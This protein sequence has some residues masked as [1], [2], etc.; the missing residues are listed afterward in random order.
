[1]QEAEAFL[2]AHPE[3]HF[4]DLLIADMNGIVRGKRIDRS[5]LAKA[6]EKGIA[7]P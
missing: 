3:I 5:A 7:L 1:M 6:F 4:I 2:V